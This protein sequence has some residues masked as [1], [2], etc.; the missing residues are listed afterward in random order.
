MRKLWLMLLFFPFCLYGYET[1]VESDEVHYNGELITLTG[2]VA[3]ENAMGKVTA[4]LAILRK[5]P[6][7]KTKI[8]LPWIELK[9]NVCLTLAEGGILRCDS[10]SLDYIQMT[11]FFYGTPQVIYSGSMGEI[12]ADKAQVDYKEENSS[13]KATKITLSDNVR[14]VNIGTSEKPASQY[15][16]ADEVYYF[17]EEQLT[18]LEGKKNRVLFY[19]KQR[20]L[21]L[22][23]RTVRAQR[24]PVTKKETVQGVGDVRFVFG[25]DEIEKI[26]QRFEIR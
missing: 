12:Y 1:V 23:A 15:A 6:E 13:L 3:V 10:L 17:P 20:D 26:K 5:D 11:S 14:L 18:I 25:P 22:S 8:D 24:D 4:K 19:D 7:K 9:Q 2:N 21:Q 16:L